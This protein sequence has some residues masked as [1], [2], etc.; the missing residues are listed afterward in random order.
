[1]GRLVAAIHDI[2]SKTG[3]AYT[4]CMTGD[5]CENNVIKRIQL[6]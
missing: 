5:K 4:A 6:A 1:M 3:H 2:H